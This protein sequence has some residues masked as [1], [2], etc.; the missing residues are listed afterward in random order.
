MRIDI[1]RLTTSAFFLGLV[2][3]DAHSEALNAAAP[4]AGHVSA[5]DGT[6]AAGGYGTREAPARRIAGTARL[7]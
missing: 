5:A 7:N 2:F 1:R 6:Y 4:L 3:A